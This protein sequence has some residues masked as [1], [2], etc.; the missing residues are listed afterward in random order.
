MKEQATQQNVVDKLVKK[1]FNTAFSDTNQLA[2]VRSSN[3][4]LDPKSFSNAFNELIDYDIDNLRGDQIELSA[5]ISQDI[6][7]EFEN[8]IVLVKDLNMIIAI[9]ALL[10]NQDDELYSFIMS[11]TGFIS[12]VSQ[13]H[14]MMTSTVNNNNNEQLPF[15]TDNFVDYLIDN[16]TL[17]S[18]TP[19]LETVIEAN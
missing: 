13:G 15:E 2:I 6:K 3:D 9:N 12:Y 10:S 16:Y 17:L 1:Y 18:E 11:D 8:A 7:L 5:K 14:V 4:A 19:T